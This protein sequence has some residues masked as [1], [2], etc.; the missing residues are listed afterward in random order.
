M[1]LGPCQ[2]DTQ[3]AVC[4]TIAQGQGCPGAVAGDAALSGTHTTDKMITLGGNPGQSYS[5]TLHV[6]GEVEAKRYNSTTLDQSGANH[7]WSV[8]GTPVTTDAYNVYMIRVTNPGAT[9]HTD[10][11]LNMLVPPGASNHTTYAIDYTTGIIPATST[12]PAMDLRLKAQG[13]AT[14]RLVAAD[15]NCS[16]IKNCGP[17]QNDGN[18]CA[19]PIVLSNIEPSA[20]A[21]NPTFNFTTQYNGQWIVVTVKDVTSP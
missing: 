3:A 14:L 21:A 6:Q 7:G 5:I 1:F 11:F 10:Y 9:T 8:G 4:A 20:I 16:M 17:T 13:G 15:S 12:A 18:T 2:R 19:A